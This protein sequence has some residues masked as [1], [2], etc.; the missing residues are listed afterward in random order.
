T[1][2][3]KTAEKAHTLPWLMNGEVRRHSA[4]G[5]TIQ[6]H[7]VS[8]AR[9]W[10]SKKCTPVLLQCRATPLAGTAPHQGLQTAVRR[11]TMTA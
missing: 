6:K 9:F 8:Q 7:F 5:A 4:I 2:L 1:D 10:L 3:E 11:R